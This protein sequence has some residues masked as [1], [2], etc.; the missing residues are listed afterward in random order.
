[1]K[2]KDHN[3]VCFG[4]ILWDNLPTGR[5]PG[6]APMNVAYHLKKLGINSIL[7]SRVGDDNNGEELI[8]F[9]KAKGL[10]I[11]FC[12]MD[13]DYVTST[14]EV[15]IGDDQEVRYDIVAPVAWDYIALEKGLPEL[16]SESDAFVFG[17]LAT[18]NRTSYET[19]LSLLE[20]A[21]C[22]VFDV[23]LRA[24]HFDVKKIG[25]L[26][27]KTD[28]LKL[29]IH[30]LYLISGWF[31]TTCSTESDRISVLQ[32]FFGIPEIVLTKGG[33]GASYYTQNAQC[34]YPAFKVEVNDTVGSG[35][36]FLAAFLSKR[37]KGEGIEGTLNY[38]SA[39]GAFITTHSGACP[40]YKQYD[41]ERF[42][43]RNDLN[44]ARHLIK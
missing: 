29:N 13:P 2:G 10:S 22:K 27:S 20:K 6:G 38:A 11:D 28:I 23:N 36:S 35:D 43:W 19:L 34:N 12:Q 1:M 41:L 15:V 21:S 17:S 18:R 31:S 25:E 5:K 37:I 30:E 44:A 24:P 16:V 7:I 3:V 39:L 26:L 9:I 14:V 32:N 42:I 8:R 40:E 4:E 33:S